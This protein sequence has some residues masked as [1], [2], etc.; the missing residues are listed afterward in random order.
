MRRTSIGLVPL[1]VVLLSG[2][3]SRPP[4][5]DLVA[6]GKVWTG[7]TTRPDAQAVA[8][9][10]DTVVAVGDSTTVARY[11]GEKT[12]VLSNGKALITPGFMD[13]HVHFLSGGYQLSVVA[14]RYA[15]SPAEFIR[16]I[17]AY[18]AERPRGEWI[19][20]GDWDHERW[21]GAPLPTREWIDSVT[22]NNPVFISRLDGHMALANSRALQLA[23]IS[24]RTGD[25][26][27]GV[28]V[29]DPRS[30]EP[31]GILKDNAQDLVDALIPEPTA[32]Q[33]D[34]ALG[35]ALAFAN[36]KGVTAVAA[37]SSPWSEYA[38]VQ[39]ARTAGRLTVRMALYP[40]LS[41]WRR[42]ADTV[43]AHGPGDDW[44][45]MAGVK[46]FM[47]GSL[48]STTALFFEPYVDDPTTSGLQRNSFD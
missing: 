6:Y 23:G 43:K 15:A 36:S 28:I 29:R 11:V 5:A 2:D 40:A 19:L 8:T 14:L 38:A 30:H 42:V 45:R 21:P 41:D 20:G 22:P 37:V 12:R 16:L 35:R 3:C 9:R 47:D 33:D 25:V 31:T 17:Q 27:G 18:A 46:A 7:D 26:P 32:A 24:R 34:A 39:R 44:V 1:C 4:A 13:G 10:G 48:G